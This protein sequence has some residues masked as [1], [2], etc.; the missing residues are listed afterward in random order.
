MADR[1]PAHVR[2]TPPAHAAKRIR[3][4]ATGRSGEDLAA[5]HLR[6][7]GFRV[8]ERNA[9]TRHGEIDLIAH[10]GQVLVFVEVKT[11]RLARAGGG[12]AGTAEPLARLAPRQRAALRRLATA[13]LF[14]HA[15]SRPHARTLRFDAIGVVLDTRGELVRL[16]HV[17][18]A[19]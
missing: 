2:R 10:D 18:D 12:A 11:T 15:G 8:L 1:P 7:L 4:L 16:D 9:R 13:W 3:A 17:E 19:W 6:R 5:A 14:E